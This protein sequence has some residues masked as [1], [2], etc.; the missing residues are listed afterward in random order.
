MTSIQSE[1]DSVQQDDQEIAWTHKRSPHEIFLERFKSAEDHFSS[2]K[3]ENGST[4]RRKRQRIAPIA[5]DENVHDEGSRRTMERAKRVGASYPLTEEGIGKVKNSKRTRKTLDMDDSIAYIPHTS[6]FLPPSRQGKTV[7]Q[8]RRARKEDDETD[9]QDEQNSARVAQLKARNEKEIADIH[10]KMPDD[11]LLEVLQ[12]F[13]SHY[14]RE[15]QEL[16][17]S[18]DEDQETPSTRFGMLQACEGNALVAIA[19][20]LE[21]IVK[22]E[23]DGRSLIQESTSASPPKAAFDRLSDLRRKEAGAKISQLMWKGKSKS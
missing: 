7:T 5:E 13:S 22:S 12:Y 15:L 10:A 17:D 6:I 3:A 2:T 4:N 20:Y 14:Y 9:Q 21:E 16:E 11:S 8:T 18:D 23:L 1:D 19:I